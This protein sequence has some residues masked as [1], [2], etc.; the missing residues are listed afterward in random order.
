MSSNMEIRATFVSVFAGAVCSILLG[1][2]TAHA[3][4]KIQ[5]TTPADDVRAYKML[6]VPPNSTGSC[7]SRFGDGAQA[8]KTDCECRGG[9]VWNDSKTQCVSDGT[10]Q[11]ISYFDR[12]TQRLVERFGKKNGV[13]PV[14]HAAASASVSSKKPMGCFAKGTLTAKGD[15]VYF[16]PGCPGF[17]KITVDLKKGEKTFCSEE[18]AEKAGWVKSK[19]CPK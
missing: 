8:G 14:T 19:A 17:E 4:M 16:V 7:K 9:F 6:N 5:T 2:G 1:A 3:A 15:K 18:L 11:N 13:V 10:P 12:L